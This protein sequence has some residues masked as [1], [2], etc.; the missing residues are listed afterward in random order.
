MFESFQNRLTVRGFLVSET[1]LRI[2]T[3][4]DAGMGG[5]EL[6][7][8]RDAIG[9]PYVPGSSF[10][11]ALRS[12]L[13]ALVRGLRAVEDEWQRLACDPNSDDPA[14]RCLSPKR[15][16]QLLQAYENDDA[17][18]TEAVL[19]ESC[20]ICQVL[21][22]PWLASR[23]RVQDLPV[24]RGEWF[25]QYDVRD[26]VAIDRDKGTVAGRQLYDYQVVPAG[27]RFR[28]YL[29]A[30][31]LE[32]WQ[33][34]LLWLGI[35]ALERGDVA[36]GGFTSR[37]LGWVRLVEREARFAQDAA[38]FIQ[39]LASGQ[40]TEAL[41]SEVEDKQAQKWAKKLRQKVTG[42]PGS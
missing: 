8:L 37:G 14:D 11:G 6:P 2:G 13:E 34:G 32:P 17:G 21:G 28:L 23:V 26:G 12:H 3:G 27:T 40:T 41:G 4:R 22:S 39:F 31:N 18:L 36:I 38:T 33:R 5:T 24:P 25:G 15:M 1:A 30:D 10:K 19:S 42:Q 29:T 35:R 20:L 7:V 16:R 9:Q